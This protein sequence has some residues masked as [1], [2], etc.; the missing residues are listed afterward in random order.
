MILLVHAQ[1]LVAFE[2]FAIG[3]VLLQRFQNLFQVVITLRPL[4]VVEEYDDDTGQIE[5]DSYDQS[6]EGV[7]SRSCLEPFLREQTAIKHHTPDTW[8]C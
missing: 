2:D 5:D 6:D 3:D 8:R 7:S 4:D 1:V